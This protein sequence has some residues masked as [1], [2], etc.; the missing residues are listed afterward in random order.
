[1]FYVK[2]VFRPVKKVSDLGGL[3]LVVKYILRGFSC[4]QHFVELDPQ[5]KIC[6]H[7]FVNTFKNAP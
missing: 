6:L 7:T 4:K 1:M 5:C 2:V 3:M